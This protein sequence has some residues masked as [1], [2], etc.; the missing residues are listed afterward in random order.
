MKYT[1][2]NNEKDGFHAI[3]LEEG[4]FKGCQFIYGAVEFDQQNEGHI[5]FDYEIVNGFTLKKERMHTFVNTLGDL[6]M[7]IIE[8]DLAK[9]EVVYTG[10]C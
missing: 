3:Q 6:L 1:E 2:T 4:E 7:Q 8:E 9:H 10:G 5:H